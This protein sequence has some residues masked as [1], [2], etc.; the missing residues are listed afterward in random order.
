MSELETPPLEET[1]VGIFLAPDGTEE[2]EFAG[3]RDAADDAGATD[4]GLVTSRNPD[5]RDA[6]C[7]TV[8]EEFAPSQGKDRR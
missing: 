5:V 7:E 8:V 2:I 4:V 1:T 6:F 3:P